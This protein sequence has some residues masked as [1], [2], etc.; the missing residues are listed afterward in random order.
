[1]I[2]MRV[3][4]YTEI[5]S[6]WCYWAEPAWAEL[7]ECYAGRVVFDWKIALMNAADFPETPQ[8]CDWF[9]RRSGTVMRSPFLLSSGWV[10]SGPRDHYVTPNL[11]A[12]AARE[13]GATGDEVRLAL[14]H[15]AMREGRKV[16]R[17]DEAVAI[18]AATGGLDSKTLRELAGSAKV[19]ERVAAS[20]AEF[21]AHRINQRPAFVLEDAIGD[22]AVFSGLVQAAPLAA[23]IDAMLADT[24]AYSSYAAHHG[25]PPSA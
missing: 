4:Y 15:A 12:E 21:H 10:E 20:T 2:P 18:A 3:T 11:V 17:L 6:S 7:K 14:A 23:T 16:A 8:Q 24:A 1:M 9:Y 5:F 22:K 25:K 19:K 13:L